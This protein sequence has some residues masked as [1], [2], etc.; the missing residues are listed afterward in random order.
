MIDGTVKKDPIAPVIAAPT[1][2]LQETES[3][4]GLLIFTVIVIVATC[5]AVPFCVFFFCKKRKKV[6]PEQ[7]ITILD[8][9]ESDFA[10]YRPQYILKE[11]P[12]TAKVYSSKKLNT[13]LGDIDLELSNVASSREPLTLKV[14]NN[15]SV[16][17]EEVSSYAASHNTH[18]RVVISSHRSEKYH[19]SEAS[20]PLEQKH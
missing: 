20:V 9:E 2:P 3:N 7:K 1:P 12:S 13:S 17:G 16:I 5:I 18:S 4:V 15:I 14:G 19:N 6:L 10:P 8:E 11:R